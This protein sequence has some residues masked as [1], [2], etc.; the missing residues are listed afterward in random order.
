MSPG[1]K[2]NY[3]KREREEKGEG[4]EFLVFIYDLWLQCGDE[5]YISLLLIAG[6]GLSDGERVPLALT[7]KILP[8]GVE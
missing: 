4:E 8:P 6:G 2:E 1:E 7:F 5:K 3:K